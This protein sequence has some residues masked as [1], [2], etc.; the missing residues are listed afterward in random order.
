MDNE[1][2]N[3]N[4]IEDKFKWDLKKIFTSDIEFYSTFEKITTDLEVFNDFKTNFDLEKCLNSYIEISKNVEKLYAYGTLN[5][6]QDTRDSVYQEMYSKC[7]IIGNKFSQAASFLETKILSQDKVTLETFL[8]KDEN[9]LYKHF[10]ENINRKRPHILS[11]EVEEILAKTSEISNCSKNIFSMIDNADIKFENILNEK[12]EEVALTK[13]NYTT[14]LKNSDKN[15]RKNAYESMYNS[16]KSLTNTISEAYYST[17]KKDVFYAKVRNYNSDLEM[18]LDD[19][20]INTDVYDNLITTVNKNLHLLH[21]YV[22]IRKEVLNVDKL[23]MYDLYVPL[24]KDVD[25]NIEFEEAKEIVLN[26]VSPLGDKYCSDLKNAF[27]SN[28]IDV[29]ENKGKRGGAY[30]Y[31]VYGVNPFVLMNYNN[32]INSVFTLAHEMGH[33]MHSKYTFSKQPYI[34]ADHKIFVAEVASTVNEALLINSYIDNAKT[35]QEKLFFINYFLE[36]F[37]GTFFRQTMFAEF[38]QI[39]HNE[40]FMEKPLNSKKF[41]E[42]YKNLNEKYFGSDLVVD[43]LISYEWSRIPH[44]YNSFYVY[45]YATGFSASMSI[46]KNILDKKEGSLDKYLEFL[47]SGTSKHSLSLL[48]DAGVFMQTTKPIL[49]ALDVFSNLLNQFEELQ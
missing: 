26:G 30:S 33:A 16:Y 34:Y 17:L 7:Q 21:K 29:Y 12:N 37:R 18:Y 46:V 5:F 3:R 14:F 45:Q 2:K 40:V 27:N 10:I 22:K 42:I 4:E 38:E 32:D 23:N 31:G 13:G 39:V 9:K 24:V 36:Q 11:D 35:K 41:C 1:I 19:D 28:I 49:D 15:V 25:F 44:F 6:H 8:N 43:D 20:S 47:K 48:D